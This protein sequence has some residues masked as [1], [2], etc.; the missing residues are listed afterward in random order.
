VQAARSDAERAQNE[1]QTYVNQVIPEARGKAAQIRQA[2]EAYR[3]QTVAEASGQAAALSRSSRNTR[4]R[5]TSP[6]SGS[7][8]KPWSMCSAAPIRSSSIRTLPMEVAA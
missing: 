1:A 6:A 3:E 2:A 7:I 4:R 8:L 5:P